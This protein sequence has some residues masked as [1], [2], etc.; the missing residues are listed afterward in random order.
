MSHWPDEIRDDEQ[1]YDP[2]DDAHRPALDH[3]R[4][5]RLVGEEVG[6]A[7]P[8]PGA[9]GCSSVRVTERSESCWIWKKNSCP[10]STGAVRGRVEV[11]RL[12]PD[13]DDRN[14][15]SIFTLV[16]A[17]LSGLHPPA[18]LDVWWW[19]LT[20]SLLQ[21][22]VWVS[23]VYNADWTSP[24][25]TLMNQRRMWKCPSVPPSFSCLL[26]HNSQPPTAHFSH[27]L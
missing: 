20:V 10:A 23:L 21:L 13:S 9:H 16:F 26:N 15:V 25:F 4:L 22:T 11:N 6:D 24:H 2:V 8:R 5:G 17:P 18:S 27:H 7:A 1:L 19:N 12:S 3:H 14:V